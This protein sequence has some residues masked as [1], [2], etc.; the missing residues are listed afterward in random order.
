THGS[1]VELVRHFLG[2]SF[3]SEMFAGQGEWQKVAISAF[4]ALV[5]VGSL[6]FPS[7]WKRYSFLLSSPHYHQGLRDDVGTFVAIA[8]WITALPPAVQWQSLFPSLRDCLARASLPLR[9]R[10]IFSAKFLALLI[11]VVALVLTLAVPTALLFGGVSSGAPP[12]ALRFG[13]NALAT[14]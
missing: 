1:G 13:P 5:S 6:M 2:C 10:Q 8:M 11:L 9:S 3:D 14:F 12:R 7:Y 4:A